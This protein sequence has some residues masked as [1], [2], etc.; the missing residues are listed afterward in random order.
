MFASASYTAI[1]YLD[2][3]DLLISKRDGQQIEMLETFTDAFTDV[4]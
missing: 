4:R 3:L 1:S 2:S